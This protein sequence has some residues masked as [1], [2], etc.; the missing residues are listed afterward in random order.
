MLGSCCPY[1]RVSDEQQL[2]RMTHHC[3]IHPKLSLIPLSKRKQVSLSINC[4]NGP[5][6]KNTF[7]FR[8]R[9]DVTH[10]AQEAAAH[11]A[12]EDRLAALML[13]HHALHV[14]ATLVYQ[15]S[16]KCKRRR[17]CILM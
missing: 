16:K 13:V 10:E 5:Q 3:K 9:R 4:A 11:H 14:L 12:H 7:G 2:T 15:M 1:L 8:L 17:K 6:K